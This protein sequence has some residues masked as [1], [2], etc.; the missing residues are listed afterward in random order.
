[1]NIDK[2]SELSKYFVLL[3]SVVILSGDACWSVVFDTLVSVSVSVPLCD[4][5]FMITKALSVRSYQ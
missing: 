1:M 4:H 3:L 5:Q 2:L